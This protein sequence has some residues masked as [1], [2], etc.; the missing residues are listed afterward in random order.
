MNGVSDLFSRSFLIANRL[1]CWFFDSRTL[2]HRRR[3]ASIRLRSVK[4]MMAGSHVVLLC[5]RVLPT[6]WLMLFLSIASGKLVQV[7]V[8]VWFLLIVHGRP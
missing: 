2:A 8:T 5:L 6:S 3:V 7:T 4:R 1:S